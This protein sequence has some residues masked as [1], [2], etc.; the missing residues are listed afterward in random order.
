MRCFVFLT[1]I[2]QKREYN[3]YA[4]QF[5]IKI[6]FIHLFNEECVNQTEH[7]MQMFQV[8]KKNTSAKYF[9]KFVLDNNNKTVIDIIKIYLK[10][11]FYYECMR[12]Y[13]TSQTHK[14]SRIKF[15]EFDLNHKKKM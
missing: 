2:F 5:W 7:N 13:N 1:K 6:C 15:N 14:N 10:Y 9:Q 3:K 12:V 11:I 8:K 4:I